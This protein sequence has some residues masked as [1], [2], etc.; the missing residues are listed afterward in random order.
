MDLLWLDK[1]ILHA[2]KGIT[3]QQLFLGSLFIWGITETL[4]NQKVRK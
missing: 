1:L 4:C 3:A 2:L